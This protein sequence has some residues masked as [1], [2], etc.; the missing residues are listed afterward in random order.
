[1]AFNKSD[2]PLP[3]DPIAL[4]GID[5]DGTLLRS[6]GTISMESAQVIS[7]VIQR[8]VKIV[9]CT[10]R[11]PRG[12]K[13]IHESLGLETLVVNNDGAL[14]QQPNPGQIFFHQQLSS[15]QARAVIDI[16][17]ACDPNLGV[18]VE[19]DDRL[20]SDRASK[21][22][23]VDPALCASGNGY[24]Q[25]DAVL[26]EPV[27][28]V[29]FVGD[30]DSLSK[31]YV[32]LNSDRVDNI[33]VTYS[34]QRLLQIVHSSVSKGKGLAKVADYYKI[35]QHQVMAIGDAP[36]DL[37]MIQWAG[38]GVAMTNAWTQIR[39]A[40]HLVAPSNNDDGVAYALKRYVL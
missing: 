21:V 15:I 27:T 33:A 17:R 40:A 14:I 36:N 32:E 19:S 11:P 16:G 12:A 7:E 2:R 8:G 5:L 18:A 9:I 30:A 28:K 20:Y 1:M 13:A 3:V 23:A 22:V 39:A 29:V 24:D 26:T 6:D 35:P 10:A 38:L 34:H 4:V 37:S 31:V 25:F